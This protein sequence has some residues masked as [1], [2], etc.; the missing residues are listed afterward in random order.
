MDLTLPSTSSFSSGVL[1]VLTCTHVSL[2]HPVSILMVACAGF[3]SRR[4]M[5]PQLSH[6]SSIPTSGDF[7]GLVREFPSRWE[8]HRCSE[9]IPK[10]W[11]WALVDCGERCYGVCAVSR[12]VH[13]LQYKSGSTCCFRSDSGFLYLFHECSGGGLAC[14]LVGMFVGGTQ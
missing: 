3:Q 5:C 6:T 11:V 7:S 14:L 10:R 2:K 8:V 1:T 12:D 13:C 4:W 9:H